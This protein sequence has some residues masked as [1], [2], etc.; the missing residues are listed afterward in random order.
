[1]KN[2]QALR[3]DLIAAKESRRDLWHNEVKNIA[4]SLGVP[5]EYALII[6]RNLDAFRSVLKWEEADDFLNDRSTWYGAARGIVKPRELPIE[7]NQA[8]S[9]HSPSGDCVNSLI[10]NLND[11]CQYD[12][13]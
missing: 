12:K 2:E 9:C 7:R 1:M 6:L 11:R 13:K 8:S 10:C 3:E 5:I 4:T